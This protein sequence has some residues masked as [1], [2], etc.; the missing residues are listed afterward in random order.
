MTSMDHSNPYKHPGSGTTNPF[1]GGED[2][3]PLPDGTWEEVQH[4][5][6]V[7]VA[8]DGFLGW[9]ADAVLPPKTEQRCTTETRKNYF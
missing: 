4:C 2:W 9:V 6:T 8:R 5:E 7:Q 3:H 1:A